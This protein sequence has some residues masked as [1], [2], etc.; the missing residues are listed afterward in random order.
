[1]LED[2]TGAKPY[3]RRLGGDA[4]YWTM[5]VYLLTWLAESKDTDG[6]FSLAEVVIPKAGGEPPPTPTPARTRPT[7]SWRESSPSGSADRPWRRD[8][9]TTC[10]YHEGSSMASN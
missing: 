6:R 1:M 5:G 2:S 9:V 4:T 3:T 10:G 8:R 7:T